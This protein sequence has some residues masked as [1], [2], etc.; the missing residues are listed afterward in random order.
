MTLRGDF[1]IIMQTFKRV[2]LLVFLSG[3]YLDSVQHACEKY[4][5]SIN[6]LVRSTSIVCY[7]LMSGCLSIAI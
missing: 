3:T 2:V 1:L 5:Y 4:L 7:M 6:M